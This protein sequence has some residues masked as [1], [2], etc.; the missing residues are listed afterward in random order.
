MTDL[1]N[2]FFIVLQKFYKL[3]MKYCIGITFLLL[4]IISVGPYVCLSF[5]TSVSH[6]LM[7]WPA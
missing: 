7:Y 6:S 1:L 2:F 3:I 5:S 4:D